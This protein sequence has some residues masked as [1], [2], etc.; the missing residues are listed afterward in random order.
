MKTQSDNKLP[1]I[2]KLQG[3]VLINFNESEISIPSMPGQPAKTGYEY[4]QVK[5]SE[6]PTKGEIVSAVIRSKYSADDEL[7]LIHNGSD[8]DKHAQELSEFIAFRI[9]AKEIASQ[10]LS[11][12]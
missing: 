8:T 7:A 3:G 6:S 5:V 12:L 4:D 11:Q 10:V 1:L 9:E 2:L